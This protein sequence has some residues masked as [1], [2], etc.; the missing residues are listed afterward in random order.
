MESICL[1]MEFICFHY[2]TTGREFHQNLPES[3]RAAANRQTAGM[4]QSV[5]APKTFTGTGKF[6]YN[7]AD[8][9]VVLDME[10]DQD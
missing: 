4:M 2:A 5:T 8:V 1:S 9:L 10:Q 7:G 3:Y 6:L